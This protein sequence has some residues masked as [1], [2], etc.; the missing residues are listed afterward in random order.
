M[1]MLDRIRELLSNCRRVLN[2]PNG[3]WEVRICRMEYT[4]AYAIVARDN[5]K[6]YAIEA[7]I[8]AK[9]DGFLKLAPA[10]W[11][12]ECDNW[13]GVVSMDDMAL[14]FAVTDY[15]KAECV[16][17]FMEIVKEIVKKLSE[18]RK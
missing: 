11:W 10:L 2:D 5:K 18:V 8:E 3:N 12:V 7:L 15:G 17:K 1:V 9:R 16:A 14:I 6:E 4:V 13:L